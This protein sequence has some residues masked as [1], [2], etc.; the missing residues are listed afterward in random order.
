MN[1]KLMR[2]CASGTALAVTASVLSLS[3][4]A[5]PA[6]YSA[7]EQGYITSV[8]NQGNWGICWAFSSTAISEAS[9]IKEFPNKFNS[10]NTD[11]S[12]NLLAYMVSHPSLY[13]KLNPSGDYAT[14]TAS[15][16][17]DYLT[18]G[19]N[20]WAAGLGLMN[21]IGPYNENS[22]Y[23][24]SED[25][26][27]SI[28]NKNFTES[29]YYEVRNSSVA[30]I[31]GVFQAHINN[32]SDNDEFKQLI[33]DYGA[34]SLSYNENYTDNK[35]GED[36]SS[37][38][39]NPNENTSNHAVTVVGWDD[40]IPASAFKTT[41]AGDG[42]WLI[43]N[44]WGEYSRDNGYFWLSYYDKSISGVGIAYD[45][46]VDGADDYFDTRYSY[47]GGNSLASFGYSRPDI[48][49]ANV[50]TA[51]K[52]SYVTGAATYTSAG[53][54]IELSVY[55]S[56]KDASDPTSGTKS[57]VA[58][59]SNVKY[60]G[61]YSLKFDA[62]VKVKKGETFAIVAK[63][64][65]DSGTVRIYSEYGYS[66]NGLTYSLKANKGESFYTYNPSYGWFDCT[67]SGKNNL[68]I[69]AYAV[70][71]ECTEHTY[72]DWI[73][74]TAATCTK[75]GAKH[76]VCKKCGAVEN[77]VIEKLGHNYSAEWT[78]D[79]PADC[80]NSGEKSRHCT[81]CD[82]RTDNI[83]IPPTGKHTYGDWQTLRAATCTEEGE[84]IRYCL[85]GC[86][87]SE[88]EVIDALGH[89]YSTE[90]T[91]D[92]SATCKNGGL[93]S[94][95]CTRCDERADLTAVP[96]TNDHKFGEW[97]IN[98]EANCTESGYKV[99]QCLNGCGTSEGCV[100]APLGH[101]YV[102]TVVKPSYTA[103]G[104][105]LHKCSVCGYSY[106]DNEMAKLTLAKVTGFKVKSKTN[107][108][109]N[110]QWDK[111]TSASGYELQKYDGSKWVT[112]KT[113][114]SNTNT[115]FNVTGLKAS[116]T[117]KFRLRAY[118]AL[119]NA[120]SYSEFTGLNV[121]TRP[122]TTTGMKCSSK[123]NVSA[124]LQWN[125]NRSADGYVLDKYDG[126]KWVTIKTFTS[127]TNTSF[128]V[129]GL[130]ASKT[131]K[132]RL[133]AYKNFGSVKEYSAFTYLNV[134]TR[135]YTTTGMKCSSKTNVSANLQWNK[136]R[137]AD[138]Y[139]LDKYDGKK[140]V[141]I[142]TFTSNANTSFN[143]TGLKAS[144]TFKFRL[145]AYKNF[146]SAKEYSA[147]TYLNV[148]TRPYTTTG[149]KMKSATKNAI[150]LQWNKNISASG[151]C[152]EKWNGSKWVQ[153]KRYTSNANVTYTAT[154]L[155][156]NTAYKFRIRAYKTI[157]NVNEYSAYSAV[158][159]A[160]TKK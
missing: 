26:T 14:Y 46:T 153:I 81:R 121:N 65:K 54:N 36:G 143:V 96:K 100:T 49:G 158:V 126:S 116:T 148:N 134:N 80:K 103:Q 106:K 94:H 129:T 6:K 151:Y 70:N 21:G 84:R 147:F 78:V 160:R 48:Y 61:Y 64:T 63:I 98:K 3:V 34:A 137:S 30:K 18:L 66:M 2:I 67:D 20:V 90:W 117:Y 97:I 69:K 141:T 32:N 31:T 120:N 12:E 123:T 50:F 55:T 156:A 108:S 24:Y 85:G 42:A 39:Y 142:K 118:K 47:D 144:T 75:D 132:F 51:D 74:D 125:K 71:A 60:E 93:K 146:G 139:V 10:G 41:P 154:G 101:K 53:N 5:A 110:L 91:I 133:R 83:S 107:V 112:I 109:A 25:N 149:F 16:A 73:T 122:Y 37:Y 27:P 58:T 17:T 140:W 87:T 45:F 145:R 52:D 131:F 119:T 8:K 95:H 111:N 23:P 99:R 13:G 4:Y 1:K 155:K 9:L 72:G 114:T 138:G 136:N 105:T 59:M 115:S 159:T 77:G 43:K 113:F 29:E 157:G 92:V 82:A 33:M 7:V 44:S 102:D 56:L 19:G 15:S 124:N 57:A 150:T 40:S 22:D 89:D 127:N 104:Y 76:R 130:K 79:K 128:N 88:K 135:P 152:I 38:Y 68:M 11:L 86:G 28:V 62:P 35:F